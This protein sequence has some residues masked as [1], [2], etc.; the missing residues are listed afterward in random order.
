M[1]PKVYTHRT[2]CGR[3]ICSADVSIRVKD[4]ER[5]KELTKEL[6]KYG[7]VFEQESPDS[8]ETILRLIVRIPYKHIIVSK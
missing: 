6:E 5:I 2:N 3:D 8:S 1:I 7:I 4:I